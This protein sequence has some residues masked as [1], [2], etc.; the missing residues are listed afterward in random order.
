MADTLWAPWR[1][2]YIKTVADGPKECFLCTAAR[3]PEN[4]APAMVLTR[5]AHCLMLLNHYPYVNGHLL[6][7]PYR[8]VAELNE[9]TPEEQAEMMALLAQGQTL[10]TRAMNP[11]GF[12]MGMNLGRCAGAGLPGHIHA[13]LVPRWNGDINFMSVVGTV[14][15]IPQ[16]L[17]ET[18][19]LLAETLRQMP[20]QPS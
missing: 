19:K 18:Y 7:A 12:N 8:H 9:L 15:I 5:T 14:R 3:A 1:M 20:T 2:D 11:H 13:H 16:A 17:E 6:V 4:D 10:L